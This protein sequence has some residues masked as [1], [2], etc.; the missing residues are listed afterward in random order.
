MPPAAEPRARVDPDH[1]DAQPSPRR[2]DGPG[3]AHRRWQGR[4]VSDVE[5]QAS[6]LKGMSPADKDALIER[7]W[8]DLQDERARSRELERRLDP[9][10]PT[11]SPGERHPS[12]PL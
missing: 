12:P 2:A 5:D 10:R 11:S 9:A 6:L 3:P 8:R 1:G 7:L 4:R